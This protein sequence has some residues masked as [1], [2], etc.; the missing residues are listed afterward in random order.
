MFGGAKQAIESYLGW[1]D[2]AGY[3]VPVNDQ[4][5]DWLAGSTAP[6]PRQESASPA[7]SP[8]PAPAPVRSAPGPVAAAPSALLPA[9]LE[10]FDSWWA[11]GA[12]VPGS[13]AGA[14]PVP[15]CGPR[16]ARLMIITDCPDV[17]DASE[18]K[19]FAGKAG[20]LLDAMLGAIGLARSDVRIGALVACRPP[21]GM[22]DPALADRLAHVAR[23]HVSLVRPK[24]MLVLGQH[25]M[26]TLRIDPATID[27]PQ[28]NHDGG[29][30]AVRGIHHPRLLIERPLLKRQA[31]E[32]LKQVRTFL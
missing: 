30:V 29:S 32:A 4:R 15:A 18:G 22:I 5:R 8:A 12:D 10:A 31:W 19:L 16:D 20:I 7:R 13:F 28:F 21:G 17:D 25:A 9:T 1:W 3:D 14:T 26:R 6:A 27:Q 24:A 11:D 2:A 23:H